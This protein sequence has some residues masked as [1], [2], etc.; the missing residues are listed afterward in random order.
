VSGLVGIAARGAVDEAVLRPAVALLQQH[1]DE[2]TTRGAIR[3]AAAVV[4]ALPHGATEP[5]WVGNGVLVA[6]YGTA[7]WEDTGKLSLPR[8]P[9]ANWTL[10]SAGPTDGGT[11]AAQPAELARAYLQHGPAMLERLIGAFALAV[12][13][14]RAERREALVATDRLGVEA[15]CFALHGDAFAFGTRADAVAVL[16]GRTVTDPQALYDYLYFHMV[17]APRTI[18]AGVQRLLP[19][20]YAR[21]RDGALNVRSYWQPRF[22]EPDSAPFADLAL[23]FRQVLNTGVTRAAGRTDANGNE[24]VGCFLSGGTDSSTVSGLL[25]KV[26]GRPAPTFSIGFD[27]QGYDEMEFARVAAR[28]FAT[29]HRE[30]YVTPDDVVDAVARIAGA[31]DQPFGNASV[32]PA[33]YCARLAREH[34]ITRLLA[35]DGGD[36]LYGGNERY[37]TQQVFSLYGRVPASLRRGLLEPLLG[38]LPAAGLLRKA[39]GYVRQANIRLPDRLQTYNLLERTGPEQVLNRDF[40]AGLDREAP[41]R[42]LRESYDGAQARSQINRLLALDLRFTLADSD[43][44][45]VNRACELAGVEVAYPLLDSAVVDFSLQLPPDYKLKGTKLR[46]FFKEALRDFLPREVIE[47]KKHGFGL[48]FGVWLRQHPALHALAGDTLA[49]LR[50]RHIVNDSLIDELLDAKLGEH[51]G[52]YGTLVW[53]LMTLELWLSRSQPSEP[54]Y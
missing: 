38:A 50:K 28:H 34:G 32:L 46:W 53:V 33:Y 23:Q 25:A 18:F 42:L 35:G 43:L 14:D 54:V 6:L 1:A 2:H 22:V 17:P 48:P 36:E 37:A 20:T 49:S 27:A 4:A 30:Y 3:S 26:T 51:A 24:T 7:V 52:Y 16:A 10:A 13:V 40:L 12:V 45:K 44:P 8:K 5:V 47:K 31:H 11:I 21:L 39:K 19:G 41:L 9:G 29:A 15:M